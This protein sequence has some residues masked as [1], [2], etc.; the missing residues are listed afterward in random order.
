LR[1]GDLFEAVIPS[2]IFEMMAM[3]RPIIMGVKG[4]SRDIVLE[5]QAGVPMEPESAE[6]LVQSVEMLADDPRLAARLGRTARDYV[7]KR[8]NR[9]VLAE[10][11]IQV[12]QRNARVPAAGRN[13]GNGDA[14]KAVTGR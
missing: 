1:K 2:K 7:A 13:G 9:D 12:L 4:Q 8:F 11:Y 6:S 3:G 10:E 5:A 14:G